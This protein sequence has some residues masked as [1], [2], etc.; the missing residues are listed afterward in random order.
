MPYPRSTTL[1][2]SRILQASMEYLMPEKKKRAIGYIRESKLMALDTPTMES[3]AKYVREYCRR[4]GYD[5]DPATDEYR[6]SQSAYEGPYFERPVLMRAI[7]DSKDYD[8]FVCSE[9][10]SLSRRGPGEVMYLY[11]LLER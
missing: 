2:S 11:D 3:Q 7:G 5:Y 6:E 1:V 10:R 4:M 9:V 8:V